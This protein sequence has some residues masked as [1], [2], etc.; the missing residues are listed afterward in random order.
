MA[1]KAIPKKVRELVYQ[2]YGGH[3]AYCGCKLEYKDM[4]VDHVVSVYKNDCRKSFSES[5]L[6]D[7]EL[8]SA[9]NF[10]PACRQCNFYKS[11]FD[12]EDFRDNLSHMMMDNLRKNF[13]YRLA[14]KYG[15]IKENFKPV[16]FYFETFDDKLPGQMNIEDII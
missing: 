3:C 11:T 4:Q 9:A 1:R 2:K 7:E 16:K 14:I 15:L 10:M 12:L 8:N 6:S 5:V 13:N